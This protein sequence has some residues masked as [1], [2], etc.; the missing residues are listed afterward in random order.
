MYFV[1]CSFP[2]TAFWQPWDELPPVSITFATLQV[3]SNRANEP[4][5]E[6]S[7]MVN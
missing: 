5:S 2:R 4:W 6:T 7:E 3:H 1:P